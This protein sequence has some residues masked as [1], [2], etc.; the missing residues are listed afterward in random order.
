MSASTTKGVHALI[1]GILLCG[2]QVFQNIRS[3]DLRDAKQ[4]VFHSV[5]ALRNIW[6]QS[7]A[8]DTMTGGRR[9]SL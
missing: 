6:F 8:T 2:C 1:L 5:P 3:V 4:L 9:V 7:W